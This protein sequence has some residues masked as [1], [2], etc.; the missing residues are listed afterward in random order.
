MR[1]AANE[2]ALGDSREGCQGHDGGAKE[3]RA[4]AQP[5]IQRLAQSRQA[6]SQSYGGAYCGVNEGL[7]VV[8]HFAFD[9]AEQVRLTPIGADNLESVH[10]LCRSVR[11]GAE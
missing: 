5:P 10:G 4:H 9:R 2:V 8:V 3:F 11:A 1:T 6:R 7:G